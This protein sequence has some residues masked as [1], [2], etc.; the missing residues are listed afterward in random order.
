VLAGAQHRVR[1]GSVPQCRLRRS[2]PGRGCSVT[3]ICPCPPSMPTR[4]ILR[5]SAFSV[6]RVAPTRLLR[7]TQALQRG[8]QGRM[9]RQLVRRSLARQLGQV[10]LRV[11]VQGPSS[12]RHG[13][14]FGSAPHG[15]SWA[16]LGPCWCRPCGRGCSHAGR[17]PHAAPLGPCVCNSSPCPRW[18][19]RRLSLCCSR[20][21]ICSQV[22]LCVVCTRVRPLPRGVVEHQLVVPAAAR[23]RGVQ[24]LALESAERGGV[25]RGLHGHPWR[26]LPGN[27]AGAFPVGAC[28]PGVDAVAL[29]VGLALAVVGGA[30]DDGGGRCRP[31]TK[32]HQHLLSQARDED[33]APVGPSPTRTGP[34]APRCPRRQRPGRCH[35]SGRSVGGWLA[36][37]AASGTAA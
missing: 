33:P 2:S 27:H 17:W 1:R 37:R 21:P 14:A 13:R 28:R 31:S 10:R 7:A 25:G 30:D 15:C 32:L 23:L 24:A 36:R 22:W 35:P 34:R 9:S 8:L 19:R 29:R 3:G 26:A 12:A 20:W 6:S 18:A 5:R 4:C 11:G 16:D